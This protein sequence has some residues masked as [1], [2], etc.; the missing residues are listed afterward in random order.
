[1]FLKF[2]AIHFHIKVMNLYDIFYRKERSLVNSYS[3]IYKQKLEILIGSSCYSNIGASSLIWRIEKFCYG[4]KSEILLQKGLISV[5]CIQQETIRK[6]PK[7]I[8]KYIHVTVIFCSF[9][10]RNWVL[11]YNYERIWYFRQI[12]LNFAK[13]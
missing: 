10:K 8:Q 1:M 2:I 3:N 4:M 13:F 9:W 12:V 11:S 6:S 7:N 5:S